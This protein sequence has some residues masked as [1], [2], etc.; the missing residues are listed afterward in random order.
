[1]ERAAYNPVSAQSLKETD[2][3]PLVMAH[4]RT[5]A[6]GPTIKS[7]ENSPLRLLDTAKGECIIQYHHAIPVWLQNLPLVRGNRDGTDWERGSHPAVKTFWRYP[8]VSPWDTCRYKTSIIEVKKKKKKKSE[9]S[10]RS[11]RNVDFSLSLLVWDCPLKMPK[12]WTCRRW[13]HLS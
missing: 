2:H 6:F 10:P 1:M 5:K 11:S 8:D 4:L 13:S 7:Q 12:G 9:T 3:L